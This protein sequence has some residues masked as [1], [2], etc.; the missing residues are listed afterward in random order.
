M[1]TAKESG[2][3]SLSQ[4]AALLLSHHGIIRTPVQG[5]S[6]V[7]YPFQNSIHKPYMLPDP[8]RRQSGPS[9]SRD[10]FN[11]INSQHMSL[12]LKL[13]QTVLG[14]VDRSPERL[15]SQTKLADNDRKYAFP[16]P[17]I[18]C[19]GDITS[20]RNQYLTTW[21]AIRDICIYRLSSNA[22]NVR[23]L[24]NQQWHTLL[25]GRAPNQD[26]KA[27]A[28]RES[29]T[30]LLSPE[31]TEMGVNMSSLHKVADREFTMRES[32]ENMWG[33]S[34]LLFRFELLMLDCCALDRRLFED[35]PQE[36]SPLVWEGPVL[37]CFYFHPDQP[38]HLAMVSVQNARQGLASASIRDRLSY[39]NTLHLVMSEWVSFIG[40]SDRASRLNLPTAE[41]R[42]D[43]I[44]QY[45]YSIAQFYTQTYFHYF[46]HAAIVPTTLPDS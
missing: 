38:H 7:G 5:T 31:A 42:E 16:E 32:Q 11:P 21:T 37:N 36:L 27:G 26:T 17:G 15:F 12:H 22:S 13:W 28:S 41:A 34:G 39:L 45:E 18:F 19:S 4:L 8:Q 33:I 2:L 44:L 29:L 25:G 10:K 20:R 14:T 23:L 40:A 24:S 46:G 3:W 30:L 1:E 9:A 35:Q 6:H 43:D